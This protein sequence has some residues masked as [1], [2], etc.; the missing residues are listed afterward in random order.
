MPVLQIK[1][2]S[3]CRWD[4][5]SLGEV[6]LRFDPGDE[7]IHSTRSFRV[8]EGGGEYNVA[9][10]LNTVFGCSTAVVTALAD[11]PLG[12]LAEGLIKQ[13]GVDPSEI[14]WREV[15]GISGNTRNGIYYIERG[16]GLRNPVGCSD[17]GN[18]AVSQLK[19]GDIDWRRIFSDLGTR[20]FHTGGVFTGL[21][22]TTPKVA[23]Q[24]M[25]AAKESGSVVSYDLNYRDSLWKTRGGREA[26]NKLNYELLP[27]ADVVFGAD[28]F[29]AS[30]AAYDENQFRRA[31]ETV[32]SKFPNLKVVVSTLRTVHSASRHD[33]GAVCFA[34]GNV[35]KCQDLT[36]LEVLDRVGSGDAFAAGF[37]YG[38]L[39]GD[40]PIVS[41]DYGLA[42]AAFALTSLGDA[43]SA[44]LEEVRHAMH[45]GERTVS[46]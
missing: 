23:L 38:L 42:N 28:N 45:Q 18:T 11:N 31:A 22:D 41:L 37:M 15:D 46:R 25:Q 29:A 12:R 35:H 9:R 8:F 40:E 30:V 44:T 27:Y 21:S 5:V 20:G 34:E 26:A 43:S 4:S 33:L 16:F 2:R 36:G 17:R 10:N 14:V 7:R 1:P 13:A 39:N 6:L 32:M 3:E 19:P 24:A